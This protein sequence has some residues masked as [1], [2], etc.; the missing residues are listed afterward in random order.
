M[1]VNFQKATPRIVDNAESISDYEY[2]HGIESKIEKIIEVVY[3]TCAEPIL[4]KNP[5]HG[6]LIL[7]PCRFFTS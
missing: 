4:I 5:S 1:S 3:G 2:I 7:G 6:M